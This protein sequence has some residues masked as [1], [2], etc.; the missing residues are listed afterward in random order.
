MVP[1]RWV[2]LVQD[3]VSLGECR[4]KVSCP[5]LKSL[6]PSNANT[7]F[8][9]DEYNEPL[10]D[11]LSELGDDEKVIWVAHSIGGLSV[12]VPCIST[13]RGSRL[14]SLL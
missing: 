9:F 8:K 13:W 1:A 14:L 3:Q 6:G 7:A 4:H 11:V 2:V 12:W 10:Y 5:D